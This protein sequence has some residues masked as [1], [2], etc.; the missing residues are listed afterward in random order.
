MCPQCS[1]LG[2][3]PRRCSTVHLHGG[4]RPGQQ[5]SACSLHSVFASL[6]TTHCI[7]NAEVYKPHHNAP[8]LQEVMLVV[9]SH[10]LVCTSCS[11]SLRLRLLHERIL[12]TTQ[13]EDLIGLDLDQQSLV[14]SDCNI[15]S[16][17]LTDCCLLS[18]LDELG[19]FPFGAFEVVLYNFLTRRT[20]WDT[21]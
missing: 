15:M 9:D 13:D 10:Q 4:V 14:A 17:F 18:H 20:A 3:R 8:L 16:S 5:H 12:Q 1:N 6:P 2:P 21:A 7:F 19:V 11:E